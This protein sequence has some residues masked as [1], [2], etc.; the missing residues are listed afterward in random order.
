MTVAAPVHHRRAS[1]G[2]L[3]SS[4]AHLQQPRR[5]FQRS[6]PRCAST[7]SVLRGR[8]R[9]IEHPPHWTEPSGQTE[10]IPP[11]L[12]LRPRTGSIE[13]TAAKCS[14]PRYPPLTRIRSL[15][16][17]LI[18]RGYPHVDQG[19]GSMS[20]RLRPAFSFLPLRGA[21]TTTASD[22]ALQ[23]VLVPLHPLH[24]LHHWHLRHRT[25]L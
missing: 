10:Q 16:R 4:H 8:L 21:S 18:R 13:Q 6:H 22:R 25:S 17:S 24:P 1:L 20:H 19:Q 9:E 5:M 14:I 3:A 7:P 11:Y 2:L 12:P 15:I 23:G